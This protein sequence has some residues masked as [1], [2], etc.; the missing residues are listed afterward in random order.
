MLSRN[1]EMYDLD[2]RHLANWLRLLLP[3]S[4]DEAQWAIL[5]VDASRKVVHAVQAGRGAIDPATITLAGTAPGDLAA[6]RK[7]LGVGF[8]VVLEL[9]A[10]A[11]LQGEIDRR[12]SLEEDYAAQWLTVLRALK[13]INGAGMWVEPRVLDLIPPLAAEPLQRTFDLLIPGKSAL[14]AYVFDAR[15]AD[16]HASVIAVVDGGDIELVTTH[17]G[18]ADALPGPV[19]ARG[20]KT[21]TGRV[22]SLVADRYAPPSIGLFIDRAAWQR[23]VVGPSD[24]LTKEIAAGHLVLDPAPAWLRGLLGGAQLAAL[25][26]RSARNLARFVPSSARRRAADLAQSAQERLKSTGAHPF[27]LLGFDPIELWHQ[28]RAYYRPRPASGSSS[29]RSDDTR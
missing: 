10:M 27:A 24:Q 23:I 1:I 25:A 14:L 3:P 28:V 7:V 11:R 20:W 21:Q 17:L 29:T 16:V 18:L 19:L 6:A 2:G 5:F 4:V 9:G 12:L 8:L 26:T 13:R 22:L 15:P